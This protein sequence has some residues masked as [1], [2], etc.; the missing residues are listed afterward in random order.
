MNYSTERSE[1]DCFASNY[2]NPE[3]EKIYI[4]DRGD[5]AM[6]LFPIMMFRLHDLH[7]LRDFNGYLGAEQAP[8]LFL[9]ATKERAIEQFQSS[10]QILATKHNDIR[11]MTEF[12][13]RYCNYIKQLPANYFFIDISYFEYIN[14]GHKSYVFSLINLALRGFYEPTECSV[15]S[16]HDN[17]DFYNHCRLLPPGEG[18]IVTWA[19]ALRRLSIGSVYCRPTLEIEDL[20]KINNVDDD[21][22]NLKY[23][24]QTSYN[25]QDYW[26]SITKML[27]SDN[28]LVYDEN[29]NPLYPDWNLFEDSEPPMVPQC[30]GIKM[31][32]VGVGDGSSRAILRNLVKLSEE[33]DKSNPGIIDFSDYKGEMNHSVVVNIVKDAMILANA[34]E[35]N[36]LRSREWFYIIDKQDIHNMNTHKLTEEALKD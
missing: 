18:G 32:C 15:Y 10:Y 8:Y 3:Q 25:K 21:F 30:S 6:T 27:N 34:E 17:S 36:K 12:A 14:N 5:E 7:D 23:F 13:D 20:N 11:K 28:T 2:D 29:I 31:G 9:R 26:E 33:W 16:P 24:E 35:K 1:I 19:G 4:Y 22:F